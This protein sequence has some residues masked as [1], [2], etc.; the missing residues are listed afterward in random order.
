MVQTS[1]KL[2]K[3]NFIAYINIIRDALKEVTNE[4]SDG[5]TSILCL[6]PEHLKTRTKFYV[7]D[8]KHEISITLGTTYP[9]QKVGNTEVHLGKSKM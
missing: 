3:E 7:R 4:V 5:N 8:A 1:R 9:G 6:T 2:S